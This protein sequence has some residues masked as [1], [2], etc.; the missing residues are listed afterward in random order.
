[1]EPRL[2]L[3]IGT[4]LASA[5]NGDLKDCVE[6]FTPFSAFQHL[7]NGQGLF[8]QA[9]SLIRPYFGA[10]EPSPLMMKAIYEGLREFQEKIEAEC[11]SEFGQCFSEKDR[12][13]KLIHLYGKA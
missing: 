3:G 12:L 11:D 8:R 5:F 9:K 1:M 13:V 10:Q 6:V 4:R 7:G 2:G